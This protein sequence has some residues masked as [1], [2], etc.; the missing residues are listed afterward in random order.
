MRVGLPLLDSTWHVTKNVDNIL[1]WFPSSH[2]DS[3]LYL[4]KLVE[5]KNDKVAREENHF[6]GKEKYT[7]VDGTFREQ[8]YVSC[9]FD[10]KENISDWDCEY[11][12]PPNGFRKNI[13]KAEADSILRS[14]NLF[15]YI[16]QH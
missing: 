2:G 5:I 10:E 15:K 4:S 12:G 1:Q 11:E 14:W 6:L 13:S 3:L 9:Y 16:H 8:V 7:T